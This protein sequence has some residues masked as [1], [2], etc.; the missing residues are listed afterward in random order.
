RGDMHT[1]FLILGAGLA[2][3]SAAYHL[4]GEDYQILEKEN[5]VGGVCRSYQIKG[6]TFDYTGHLLHF[7]NPEI[8]KWIVNLL[9]DN[10]VHHNRKAFIFSKGVYTDYPFQ[11]NLFGL[12]KEVIKECLMGFISA[13]HQKSEKVE[14]N[15]ENFE[16]WIMKTVGEGIAKHFMIPFNEKLWRRS[17]KQ[18]TADWVAWLV[19][20]PKLE[21]VI[22]GALGISNKPMG[23]NPSFFYPKEGGILSLANRLARTVNNLFL[24]EEVKEIHTRKR[25]V[26]LEGGKRIAYEQ[27]ISTLPLDVCLSRCVDLPVA[28]KEQVKKLEYIS[29]HVV[30][31]GIEKRN[32]SEKHWIYFPEKEYPFYRLGFPSNLSPLMAPEGTSSLSVEVSGLPATNFKKKEL[33]QQVKQG[34]YDSSILSP[35]DT[36]IVEDVRTIPHAYVIYNHQYT[37]VVPQTRAHLNQMGIH[38]IGRYGSWEHTSMED[39][40]FQG[41]EIA[42]YL[43]NS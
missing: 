43:L 37:K 27:L 8:K 23:Y 35:K 42:K 12:P 20:Q 3:L 11:A 9:G 41:K 1:R 33:L 31:L 7:R 21:D 18:M 19:P 10:I 17:L 16:E 40:L 4:N 26:I 32:L 25:E 24:N 14:A 22:N 34:L 2:G 36:I 39:A 30:N 13:V 6:F 28:M 5:E 29:V 38:S 15:T